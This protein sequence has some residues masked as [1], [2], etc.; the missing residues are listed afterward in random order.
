MQNNTHI[1]DKATIQFIEEKRKLHDE[2]LSYK[3]S[4]ESLEVAAKLIKHYLEFTDIS[5]P[6]NLIEA[7]TQIIK[8]AD[9]DVTIKDA[10]DPIIAKLESQRTDPIS[11]ADDGR[12]NAKRLLAHLRL[13]DDLDIDSNSLQI[14][15]A[16]CNENFSEKDFCEFAKT[17]EKL[18]KKYC[19]HNAEI[20]VKDKSVV[21][22]CLVAISKCFS[23]QYINTLSDIESKKS[24]ILSEFILRLE[25][26]YEA[27]VPKYSMTTAATCQTSLDLRKNSQKVFDLVVID[28]AARANPLDL[29]IPM[30]MGKKI[31]LVGDHK[32]LPHMLE[33]D[34]LK[35]IMNDPKFKDL[36]EIEKSLFERLFEMF[37]KGSKPKAILL[38]HQYRMHPEI[39]KFVSDSFYDGQLQT[40]ESITAEVRSSP[41]EINNGKAL[42]FVDVPISKGAET[43]GVSKSRPAEVEAIS[44][45]V[46]S[47]LEIDKDATVG[48]I[49]FYSAQAT[50]IN[51]SLEMLLDAEQISR[52][53][54]GTVDAFQG[55]EFDYVLLSCV[56]SNTP[57]KEG[58]LPEVGFLVKP[59]RLC[60]AFSRAIKQLIAYGDASTL[61]QI[62]CFKKLYE[63]AIDGGGC[64]REC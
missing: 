15:E 46:K 27:L 60:V 40:A 32:Q 61:E 35:I 13:M 3:N 59:N 12:I 26:E 63:I 37:A 47:I 48:I 57:K 11:F 49:T 16:V 24:L 44:K 20:D 43:P 14:I 4:G 54:V 18:Q 7:A 36:P 25:Q 50:K 64:Y 42:T 17:I 51:Q 58:E 28:E 9:S 8:A 41:K 39:C 29:F 22:E 45:D 38:N 31:V 53:E 5:Y 19:I 52:V 34:V 62:P 21:N 30:S 55:K 56:R 33:P 2:Y 10:P 1:E 23:N 6:Q